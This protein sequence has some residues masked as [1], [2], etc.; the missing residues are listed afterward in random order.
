MPHTYLLNHQTDPFA[1][2]TVNNNNLVVA[3]ASTL[4]RYL[5]SPYGS[6]AVVIRDLRETRKTEEEKEK[7]KDEKESATGRQLG[8]RLV[9][10]ETFDETIF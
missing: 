10:R 5:R 6:F 9:I 2:T 3:F 7:R 1:S 8:S 4:C